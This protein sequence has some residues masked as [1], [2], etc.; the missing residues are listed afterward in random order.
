MNN[1]VCKTLG[2]MKEIQGVKAKREQQD[3]AY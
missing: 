3:A 1:E 2:D